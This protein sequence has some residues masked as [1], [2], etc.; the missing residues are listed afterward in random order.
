VID[1][2]DLEKLLEA[3][4]PEPKPHRLVWRKFGKNTCVITLRPDEEP[5]PDDEAFEFYK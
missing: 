4:I 3:A 2:T 5:L 1:L